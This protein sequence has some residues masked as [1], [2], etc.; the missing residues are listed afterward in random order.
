MG[1]SGDCTQDIKNWWA[2]V[3]FIYRSIFISSFTLYIFSWIPV[4]NIIPILL[5]DY[6]IR[7]VYNF[8]FWTTC[9]TWIAPQGLLNV[10]FGLYLIYHD[11][12]RIERAIGSVHFFI[13]IVFKNFLIQVGYI[14]IMFL[15]SFIFSSPYLLLTPSV[16]L[17]PT[18][19]LFL[20]L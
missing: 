11:G 18:F 6:P 10:L 9:T 14:A 12:K 5:M 4:L 17:F 13:E 16:G 3:N 8:F 7:T 2:G 15:G 20:A 19:I 1:G